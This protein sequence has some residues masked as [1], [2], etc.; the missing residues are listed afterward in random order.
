MLRDLTARQFREWREYDAIEPFGEFRGELRHGQQ[1]AL[2]AN[3]NRSASR[4][5][6]TAADFMNFIERPEEREPTDEEIEAYLD[7]CLG[8]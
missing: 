5:P 1:M 3:L 4:E 7:R 6:F 2:T 8:L